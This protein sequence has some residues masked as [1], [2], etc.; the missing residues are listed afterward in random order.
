MITIDNLQEHR[1]DFDQSYRWMFLD[2]DQEQTSPEHQ[3]HIIP[4]NPEASAFLWAYE[5]IN[6]P[7]SM[8]PPRAKY[9]RDVELW[10]EGSE[11]EVKKWLYRRGIPFSHQVLF[12]VQPDCGFVLTWKMVVK[13][14]GWI[15]CGEDQTLF[16]KTLNWWLTYQHDGDFH[17]C[18]N[19]IYGPAQGY[20]DW[21]EKQRMIQEFKD[22]ARLAEGRQKFSKNPFLKP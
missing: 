10:H 20:R 8:H 11:K 4:L 5:G 14:S 21:Q 3:D 16:D 13:Y 7:C 19:R 15:F 17:F 12:S 1:I 22:T 2:E 9:F 6:F 18:R